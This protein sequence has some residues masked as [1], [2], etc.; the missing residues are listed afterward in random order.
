MGDVSYDEE[1]ILGRSGILCRSLQCHS[2][3]IRKKDPLVDT[4]NAPV[5]P[6]FKFGKKSRS[7]RKTSLFCIA[8]FEKL[9][10]ARFSKIIGNVFLL[11]LRLPST[12]IFPHI[13]DGI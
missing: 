13:S 11:K 3:I 12:V 8:L 10:F 7:S 4:K 5:I 2:E 9:V 6:K 1:N